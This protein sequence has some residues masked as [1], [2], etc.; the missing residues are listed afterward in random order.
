MD[1]EPQVLTY[2]IPKPPGLARPRLQN[3]GRAAVV[4]QLEHAGRVRR[5]QTAADLRSAG[6]AQRTR[7]QP[8]QFTFG[9]GR[10]RSQEACKELGVRETKG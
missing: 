3:G 4:L 5:T 8:P 2:K 6:G 10:V 1:F 7:D 9:A